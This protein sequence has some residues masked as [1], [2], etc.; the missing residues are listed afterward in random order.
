MRF[1]PIC[2]ECSANDDGSFTCDPAR[3]ACPYP[4]PGPRPDGEPEQLTLDQD[5][6]R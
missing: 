5:V 4:P 1:D 2:P 6:A 3:P